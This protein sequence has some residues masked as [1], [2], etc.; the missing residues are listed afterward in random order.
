[1]YL[2]CTQSPPHLRRDVLDM[3]FAIKNL[4]TGWFTVGLRLRILFVTQARRTIKITHPLRFFQEPM[5]QSDLKLD[6]L[7]IVLERYV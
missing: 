2:K 1:M 5:M 7:V 4:L 3:L 6:D